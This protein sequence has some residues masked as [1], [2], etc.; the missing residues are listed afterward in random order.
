M[1]ARHVERSV[2]DG[3]AWTATELTVTVQVDGV[4]PIEISTDIEDDPQHGYRT[5]VPVV[6]VARYQSAA[7]HCRQ[8]AD[9]A[10]FDA[11]ADAQDEMAM[12]RCQLATAGRLDLIGA[13]A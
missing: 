13:G 9:G 10:D 5:D 2:G 6:A 8:Y 11:C 4:G 3:T 1:S 12:C 7:A